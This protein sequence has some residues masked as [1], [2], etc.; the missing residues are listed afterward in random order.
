MPEQ[1]RPGSL[2]VE[3][4]SSTHGGNFTT[5]VNA[6]GTLW[7]YLDDEFPPATYSISAVGANG[8][9]RVVAVKSN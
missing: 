7:D 6:Y 3:V 1:H 9:A 8:S 2:T 5:T 4:L